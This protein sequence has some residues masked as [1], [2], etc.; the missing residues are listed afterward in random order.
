MCIREPRRKQ[1]LAGLLLPVSIAMSLGVFVLARELGANPATAILIVS[2]GTLLVAMAA[3]QAGAEVTYVA[4]R[5]EIAGVVADLSEP[6][7]VVL[8]MGAGD[9]TLVA[10]EVSARLGAGE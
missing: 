5:S 4:R 7:D 10:D 9:I 2:V 1:A 3:E 6:G 8:M